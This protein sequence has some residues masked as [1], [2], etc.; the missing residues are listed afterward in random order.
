MNARSSIFNSNILSCNLKNEGCKW[1]SLIIRYNPELTLKWVF[2]E[3]F[4]RCVNSPTKMSYSARNLST[5]SVVI[6]VTLGYFHI[7]KSVPSFS[8]CKLD[9]WHKNVYDTHNQI[10]MK[11]PL[12]YWHPSTRLSWCSGV[13]APQSPSKKKNQYETISSKKSVWNY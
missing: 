12:A 6:I 4:A 3:N 9:N 2:H 11:L 1:S 8:F 5:F 13:L 10:S 7:Y